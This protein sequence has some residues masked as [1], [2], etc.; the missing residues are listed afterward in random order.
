[1]KTNDLKWMKA[2]AWSGAVF[3]AF[4]FLHL[5]NQ[6]VASLG[7][8]AYDGLQGTLR[9]GYQAPVVEV[10]LVLA[11]LLVH[12]V[13]A[14]ARMLGR[15]GRSAP[16]LVSWRVRLHRWSGYFLL[17]VFLGHVTATR[18]ASFF[19]DTVPGFAGVAFTFQW[20]PAYFFP[21]YLLLALTGWYHLMH[22]L[23]VT[24][25]LLGVRALTVLGDEKVFG[26][27]VAGGS[28]ALIAGVLSLGGVFFDVG[29]PA[30]SAYAKLVLRLTGG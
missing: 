12:V 9:K 27:V 20:V 22:G 26:S 5:C 8:G 11:P 29:D 25:P 24:L 28:I 30:S 3:A 19:F 4:L 13:A 1:M 17:L 2:Q 18:G 7:P 16:G 6:M 10:L 23:S 21:Y 15:R 14:I